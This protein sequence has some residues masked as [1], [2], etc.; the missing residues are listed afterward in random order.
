MGRNWDLII[1]GGQLF[2]PSGLI[3]ADVAVADGR[4]VDIGALDAAAADE[5]ARVS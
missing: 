5:T 2:T 4:I 1:T 3:A